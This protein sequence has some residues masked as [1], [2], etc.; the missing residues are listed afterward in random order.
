MAPAW[1]HGAGKRTPGGGAR[2]G[3]HSE[4]VAQRGRVRPLSP[5]SASTRLVNLQPPFLHPSSAR[6]EEGDTWGVY[7]GDALAS[8]SV[9]GGASARS[10]VRRGRCVRAR[11]CYGGETSHRGKPSHVSANPHSMQ[12]RATLHRHATSVVPGFAGCTGG[13]RLSALRRRWCRSRRYGECGRGGTMEWRV[14][15]WRWPARCRWRAE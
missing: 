12:H 11:S 4:R 10:E 3:M 5:R 9:G 15:A 1:S 6:H 8:P 13:G 2:R 7:G 14:G